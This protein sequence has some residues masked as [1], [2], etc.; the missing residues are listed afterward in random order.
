MRGL[1]LLLLLLLLLFGWEVEGSAVVEDDGVLGVFAVV[2]ILLCAELV[3]E[4]SFV[5]VMVLVLFWTAAGGSGWLVRASTGP[6]RIVPSKR[7]LG[8]ARESKAREV[9]SQAGEEG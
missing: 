4:E 1:L 6:R 7:E 9:F 8:C 3:V 2:G 5:V